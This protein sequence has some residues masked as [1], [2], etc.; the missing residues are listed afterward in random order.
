VPSTRS[1]VRLPMAD[2]IVLV[3]LPGSGKSVVGR[4]LA[5]RLARPFV[6]TDDLVERQTGR[7]PAVI[8]DEDGEPAFR[9][10]E[11]LA[12]GAIERG[13]VVATG[14]G[15]LND[16]LNRW[17][18]WQ[19]GTAVWL[20]APEETLVSRLAADGATRPLLGPEPLAG[21]QR[22]AAERAPYYRAA[23]VRANAGRPPSVIADELMR[24]AGVRGRRLFDAEVERHHPLG[25]TRGR[26]VLGLDLE[27]PADDRSSLIVD[28]RLTRL[29]PGL[30]ASLGAG[31]CMTIAGGE[32]AKRMRTLERVLEWLATSRAERGDAIVGAGGGTVGDLAGLAAA[33]YARG[34]PYIAVPTTW[35][36]QA[37]AALGGK[38]GVDL[39]GAKNAVGAFWPPWSV[40]ADVGMLRT[41]PRRRLR[42]GLDEAVKAA[43]IGDPGLWSLLEER[44]RAAL[45][46]DEAARYAITERAARVKLAIVSRDPFELGGRRQLNLGH[47]LG[48]ALEIESGYRLPHGAA[49]A[50][51][52]RAVAGIAARRGADADLGERLDSLLAD[53]GFELRHAFEPAAVRHALLGD[54]KR[55][56]GRQRW[57]LPM[58]IGQVT[59]VDDVTDAE[60]NAALKRIGR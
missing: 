48:H 11:R 58:G 17:D 45:G 31:R 57:L 21:L 52:L 5:E 25:P 7:A 1:S 3:G 26:V 51:G 33:L 44:G 47:T 10:A 53:L 8:I 56:R 35:L 12:I 55:L 6:D 4:L 59:E 18:L 60:L 42:D 39:A 22:L 46:R 37:D 13:A 24:V 32:R 15:A 30:I 40:F 34:V 23:A 29:Q 9:A 50:L 27:L 16:P 41:L 49:V 36:A 20:E 2:G 38:V 14:G 19:Q 54:K 43:L 28:A